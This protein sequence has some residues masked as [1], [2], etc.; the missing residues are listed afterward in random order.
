MIGYW[1]SSV[2]KWIT[3]KMAD[4]WINRLAN[5]SNWLAGL[6]VL[7]DWVLWRP[8][9]WLDAWLAVYPVHSLTSWLA[10]CV[11]HTLSGWVTNSLAVWLTDLLTSCLSDWLTK[12]QTVW[13]TDRLA[14]W[15][16]GFL[17]NILTIDWSAGCQAVLFYR[18]SKRKT[19]CPPVQPTLYLTDQLADLQTICC[20][21]CWTNWLTDWLSF[22]LT[23]ARPD[24]LT[25]WLAVFPILHSGW[26]PELLVTWQILGFKLFTPGNFA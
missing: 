13:V 11:T 6:L 17:C 19:G 23:Y 14:D 25:C 15:L 1:G 26:L 24:W 18:M 21:H 20:T 12:W 8:F 5:W 9:K 2:S 7:I 16:S 10:L 22:C 3:G 4:Q